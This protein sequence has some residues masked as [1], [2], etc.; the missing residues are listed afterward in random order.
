MTLIFKVI[1][2]T[3]RI[4][5]MQTCII[6]KKQTIRVGSRKSEL[7]L[8]QTDLIIKLLSQHYS[9]VEFEIV[10]MDTIGDKIL[11]KDLSKIGDKS[12]FTKELELALLDKEI[13]FVVHSLKDVPTELSPEFALGCIC[14][15][16]STDDAVVMKSGLNF[17]TLDQ[18]PKD[19]IV[20][21][22]SVRRIA[23]MKHKFSHLKFQS[24]R[25]NLNTRLKKLDSTITELNGDDNVPN[26]S[27]LILAKAGLERI[28]LEHRISQVRIYFC[29]L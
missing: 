3:F 19:S 29:F 5:P 18:L 26:Y 4:M 1:F 15:R 24:V 25:G 22:S 28:G 16:E 2:I 13:D 9:N 12:L 10:T 17:K 8:K 6:S 27:A 23:Q 11:N 21:T 14:M 20:G 7:A